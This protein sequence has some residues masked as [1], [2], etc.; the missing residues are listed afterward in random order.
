MNNNGKSIVLTADRTLMTDFSGILLFGF[1]SCVSP[2]YIPDFLYYN[3]FIPSV[4][5]N[6]D[7]SVMYAN[8]ALRTV[9]A[10][11]VKAGFQQNEVIVAHPDHLDRVIGRNTKIVG[12]SC[13]DPMG[14]GPASTTMSALLGGV[15]RTRLEFMKLM[16]RLK[17]LKNKY[18]FR[19]VVG[20]PGA[21]QID[22]SNVMN[23]Y[24]IDYLVLGESEY[25]VPK[26]FGEIID[27]NDPLER[28][29]NSQVPQPLDIPSILHPTIAGIVEIS[30]GCGRGCRF[31]AP[32]ISGRMRSI[33]YEKIIQD[34]KVNVRGGQRFIH[35]QSEDF[36]LYGSQ[37]LQPDKD[38]VLDLFKTVFNVKGVEGICWTHASLAS[39]A[40]SPELID[41]LTR[42]LKKRG[43]NL[44]GCQPGIETGSPR[45]MKALMRGKSYPFSPDEWPEVVKEAYKI[46]DK[47]DW[48]PC[49]T[50]VMGLPGE[51][52]EDIDAT[53]ELVKSLDKYSGILVP[54][55]F[56]PMTITSLRGQQFF[57]REHMTADHWKLLSFCW[58]H[59]MRYF[60]PLYSIGGAG[61]KSYVYW[62][63]RFLLKL[64]KLL[65][66]RGAKNLEKNFNHVNIQPSQNQK[67]S[68]VG[69]HRE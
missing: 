4:P 55:F 2:K 54:M 8:C 23:D 49:S 57:I 18:D 62:T 37:K 29:V 19:V 11:C 6:P 26:L 56:V 13:V 66:N 34:V 12:V 45:L 5:V 68:V 35:F 20:G 39:I 67:I 17:P 65:I 22:A 38:A 43:A 52:K 59:N 7:G 69:V 31:C 21:W 32:T 14:I 53:L 15:S 60:E 16:H 58:Q 33:P 41:E 48:H 27:E 24:S 25:S 46:M 40:S 50:L 28:V 44:L 51:E 30:R 63:T 64:M 36:L 42:M 3:V 10:N 1:A 61:Q 47:N 9:E